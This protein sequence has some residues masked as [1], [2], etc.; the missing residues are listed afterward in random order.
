[1]ANFQYGTNAR[2]IAEGRRVMTKG[3]F[4]LRHDQNR[5]YACAKCNAQLTIYEHVKFLFMCKRCS[6]NGDSHYTHWGNG[7]LEATN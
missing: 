7:K 2:E 4:K 6:D 1:M 5:K 3:D